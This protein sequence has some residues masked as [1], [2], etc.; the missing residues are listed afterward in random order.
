MG[1][2]VLWSLGD[3][4]W[5]IDGDRRYEVTKLELAMDMLL[6]ERVRR[7]NAKRPKDQQ[8]VLLDRGEYDGSK[9]PSVR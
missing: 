4:Y 5:N 8:I 2:A 3:D 1:A 9:K 7:L 6:R